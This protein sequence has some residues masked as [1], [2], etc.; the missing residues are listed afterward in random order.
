ME[1][2]ERV[3]TDGNEHGNCVPPDMMS[4]NLA[5][6]HKIG[7]LV[8]GCDRLYER[9]NQGNAFKPVVRIRR[10]SLEEPR[11]TDFKRFEVT[12]LAFSLNSEPFDVACIALHR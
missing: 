9:L 11:S 1:T 4:A 6:S 2:A 8:N 10:L 3:K 5:I 12:L 7:G